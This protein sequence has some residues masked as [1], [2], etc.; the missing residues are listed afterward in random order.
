MFENIKCKEVMEY[1][2]KLCA[3]PHGSGNCK[4]ISDYIYGFMKELGLEARQ[5]EALNVVAHKPASIGRENDAPIILQGHMD[6]VAVSEEGMGIDMT[7]HSLELFTDG[8]WLGAKN[9]SLGGDDGIAVAMI[10]AILADEKLSH[11][12]ITAVITTEEEVGMDGA[13][14]L[15][16][17]DIDAKMLINIDSEEE[18]FFTCG[19]AG[20]GRFKA[21]H[22]GKAAKGMEGGEFVNICI[23]GLTGGHSGVEIDKGR[24]NAC[25]LLAA[26]L[27][28]LSCDF[29]YNLV[30]LQG[31]VA[32]NVISPAASA[33]IQ[34]ASSRKEEIVDY[35]NGWAKE[36]TNDYKTT[37]PEM[38]VEVLDE[39]ATDN[40]VFDKTDASAIID[41]MSGMP[42]GVIAM[43]EHLKGLVETSLNFGILDAKVVGNE[44]EFIADWSVRSNVEDKKRKL[45]EE[46]VSVA[47]MCGI[48]YKLTGDYPGWE[49]KTDSVL[50]KKMVSVYEKLYGRKPQICTIHAGLECGLFAKKIDGLDA[51]SIGPDMRNIHSTGER[52]SLSST[53]RVYEFVCEVLKK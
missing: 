33:T 13:M 7:K 16:M 40:I 36:T 49:F 2:A 47:N 38:S 51:V 43:S 8:D 35:I 37:D 10:M 9:T 53:D 50:Q 1:F 48:D 39:K 17:S 30:S 18:G 42:N 4:A 45:I 27:K 34:I 24:A 28:L 14:A 46:C 5:D 22:K 6:M 44:T 12:A 32:D 15:D 21:S 41:F 31:G 20:G 52:L 29:E 3:I 25:V 11:P 23:S 19:C 26:V